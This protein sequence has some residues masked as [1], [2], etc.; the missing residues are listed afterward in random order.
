MIRIRFSDDAGSVEI[1]AEN[2]EE[3]QCAWRNV[4]DAR[5]DVHRNRLEIT[6]A[7]HP[8][9]YQFGRLCDLGWAAYYDAQKARAAAKKEDR[10]PGFLGRV[11]AC[12]AG[13]YAWC[14]AVAEARDDMRYC[15][16]AHQAWQ[17]ARKEAT[18]D[19][20]TN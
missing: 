4:Y 16:Q 9:K 10:R 5:R 17:H 8:V 1:Q 15:A 20:A 2:A 7:I 18:D 11:S 6:R 3:L 19:G 14:R 12:Q 13:F